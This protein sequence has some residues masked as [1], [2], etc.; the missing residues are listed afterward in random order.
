MDSKIR[1]LIADDVADLRTMVRITIEIDG[2]F[3]VVGEAADG[4][5]AIELARRLRPDIVILDLSMPHMDGLEAIPEIR[6][7]S[8]TSKILV[9]SGFDERV[10]EHALSLGADAYMSKNRHIDDLPPNLLDVFRSAPKRLGE[11]TV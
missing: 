7:G 8:P 10:G 5:E 6:R 2:R 9:L 4:R 1:V 3:E 11:R